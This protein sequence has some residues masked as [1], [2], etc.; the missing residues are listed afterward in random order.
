MAAMKL[1]TDPLRA[2]QSLGALAGRVDQIYLQLP[3]VASLAFG[4]FVVFSL[5]GSYTLNPK[6]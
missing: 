6:P 5:F 2:L 3:A 1:S 4:T